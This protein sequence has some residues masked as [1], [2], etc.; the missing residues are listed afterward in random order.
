MQA[1]QHAAPH[2]RSDPQ[3]LQ[4]S[5]DYV[6][7]ECGRIPGN[8]RIGIAALRGLGHQHVEVGH[9]L[10]QHLVENI[11]RGLDA[12]GARGRFAH[13]AS[14]RQQSAQERRRLVQRRLVAGVRDEQG[15]DRLRSQVEVPGSNVDRKP[16]RPRLE[17]QCSAARLAIQTVI[18]KCCVGRAEQFAGSDAPAWAFLAAHCEQ[19]CKVVVEPPRQVEAR[20]TFAVVLHA[21]ALIGGAAPPEDRAYDVQHVFLQHDPALTIHIGLGEI[22][23]QR[24]I[25]IAQARAGQQRLH[26]VQ[27]QFEPG[28]IAGVGVEKTIGSAGGR[29][30][31]AM[32]VEH[33]ERVVMFERT[34]RASGGPGHRCGEWRFRDVFDDLGLQLGHDFS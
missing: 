22:D 12:G 1:G 21:D 9:P 32:A 27:R 30:D 18:F 26:F 11:V 15:S 6:A 19:V 29:T 33:H 10:A 5:N 34:A 28:E 23:G 2:A 17:M 7:A 4:R 13:L 14:V 20:G 31:V 25:V 8:A 24:G 3:H 16:G